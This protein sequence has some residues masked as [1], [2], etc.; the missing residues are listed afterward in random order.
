MPKYIPDPLYGVTL[1]RFN[2]ITRSVIHREA[3]IQ[4]AASSSK[5]RAH[6][7][8]KDTTIACDLRCKVGDDVGQLLGDAA[9]VAAGTLG[10][11][12]P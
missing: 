3:A 8:S 2:H 1:P 10:L 12:R 5:H 4:K 6:I 7:L 11:C 9:P